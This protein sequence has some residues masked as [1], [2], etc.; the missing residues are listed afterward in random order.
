ML[1]TWHKMSPATSADF[2]RVSS[3]SIIHEQV[4]GDDVA[5]FAL[6]HVFSDEC[7]ALPQETSYLF[8]SPELTN[9]KCNFHSALLYLL[10]AD[11][12]CLCRSLQFLTVNTLFK[13]CVKSDVK[14]EKDFDKKDNSRNQEDVTSTE[15]LTHTEYCL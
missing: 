6:A 14:K 10:L 5:A 13:A 12:C 15:T 11:I 4:L 8:P 9:T 2:S 3:K 7:A 1:Q